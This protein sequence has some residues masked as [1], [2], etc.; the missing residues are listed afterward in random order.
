MALHHSVIGGGTVVSTAMVEEIV[1]EGRPLAYIVR[2][3]HLPQETTFVTPPDLNLQVG[4]IVYPTGREIPRHA[5]RPIE[6]RIAGTN[7]VLVVRQGRCEIDV[8]DLERRFVATR[9]LRENDVIII[10]AGGHSFRMLADSVLLEV[11]QGPY[12]GVEEKERF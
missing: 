9:E 5:H 11:K 8:Y 6:R 1:S 7:E 4:F 3:L 10:V 2:S 12:P